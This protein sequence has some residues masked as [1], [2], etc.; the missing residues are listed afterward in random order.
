MCGRYTLHTSPARLA[1][2]F[3]VPLLVALAPRFN[4]APAQTVPAVCQGG[5]GREL[6]MLYWGLVPYWAKAART[7]YRL[8]NARAETVAVKPAFRAAF[9]QRRC[10]IPADGFYEWRP[11]PKARQ[12]YYITLNDGQLFAFAGLWEH[13]EGEDGQKI[14]S[15]TLIVTAANTLVQAIHER[16]P[17][18]L[19][20]EDY[21]IWLDNNSCY[22][23]ARLEALLK[24]YP[25]EQMQA[26]PVST[27]VNSPKHTD[28]SCIA[29]WL[30]EAP[31]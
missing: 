10:L 23:T 28:A 2:H 31:V 18:I 3:Q 16:M 8:I 26:W 7:G 4:I 25:A 12:P 17:V 5:A 11:G 15:C 19:A 30:T 24:P 1:E 13:W 22:N 20:P 6:V 29:P 9:R 14:E 27:R 21:A